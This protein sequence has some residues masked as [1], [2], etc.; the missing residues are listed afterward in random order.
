MTKSRTFRP[1]NGACSTK[2]SRDEMKAI[3]AA[4][5]EIIADDPPMTVRQVFY[6]LVARGA[7][8]KTG[9][10]G[11]DNPETRRA[12]AAGCQRSG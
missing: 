4:I 3:R 8:E 7:V 6:Q 2:R 10:P 11:P 1:R 5:I 12:S 9:P